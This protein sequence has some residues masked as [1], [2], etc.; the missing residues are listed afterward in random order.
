MRV[1]IAYASWFGHN[2]TI[3]KALAQELTRQGAT[4]ICARAARINADELSGVDLLVMGTYTHAG[5]ASRRLRHLCATIP[6]ERLGRMDVAVFGTQSAA[7][8]DDDQPGGVDDLLTQLAARSIDVAVPPL[9]IGLAGWAVVRPDQGIGAEED[10]QIRAF[11]MD[12]L[13]ASVAA[14]FE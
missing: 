7:L 8:L 10:R 11:A 5:R 4:V 6:P 13:E 1:I 3:A 2:R 14:P 9:R 12:L